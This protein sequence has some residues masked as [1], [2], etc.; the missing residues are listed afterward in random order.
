MLGGTASAMSLVGR[1]FGGSG[2]VSW[3]AHALSLDLEQAGITETRVHPRA[4]EP[5]GVVLKRR[6]DERQSN[7]SFELLI[8]EFAM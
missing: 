2:R 1:I 3:L 6:R 4:D 8:R 5:I 7:Q